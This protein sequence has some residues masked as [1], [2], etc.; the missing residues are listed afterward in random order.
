MIQDPTIAELSVS[1]ADKQCNISI[2]TWHNRFSVHKTSSSA[3]LSRTRI[4][5]GNLSFGDAV[6]DKQYC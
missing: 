5:L 2:T 3:I 1:I 4:V 6:L